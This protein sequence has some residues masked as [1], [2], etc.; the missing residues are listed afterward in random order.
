MIMLDCTLANL[1][2]I[3]P[4]NL[5]DTD[6][7]ILTVRDNDLLERIRIVVVGPNIV[8]TSNGVIDRIFTQESPNA[9]KFILSVDA[10]QLYYYSMSQPMQ[11]GLFTR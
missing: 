1:A 6:F 8:S 4:R 3:C 5:T 10:S 11:N 9:R 2:N 7:N